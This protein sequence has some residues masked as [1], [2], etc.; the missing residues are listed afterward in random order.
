MA[1]PAKP[2]LFHIQPPTTKNIYLTFEHE[3]ILEPDFYT[4]SQYKDLCEKRFE[5]DLGELEMML[6]AND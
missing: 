2:T 6:K 4:Q 5:K 3:D 1:N